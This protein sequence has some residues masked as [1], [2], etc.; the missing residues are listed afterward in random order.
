MSVSIVILLILQDVALL[1]LVERFCCKQKFPVKLKM[2]QNIL[3]FREQF[4]VSP[5]Y[6]V[7]DYIPGN[8]PP[9]G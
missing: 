3:E 1:S 5:Q 9:W 6:F 8:I 4:R 7:D 2:R